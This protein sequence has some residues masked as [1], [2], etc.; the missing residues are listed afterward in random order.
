MDRAPGKLPNTTSRLIAMAVSLVG[1][2]EAVRKEMGCTPPELREYCAGRKEPPFAELDRL[3]Q[4]IVRE[5]GLLIARN[6]ELIAKG[7]LKN[8]SN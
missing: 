8:E 7:R 1:D 2:A 3:I 4:L 5:Q 6:R